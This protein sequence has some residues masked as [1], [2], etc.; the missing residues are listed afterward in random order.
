[1]IQAVVSPHRETSSSSSLPQTTTVR[2][3][4]SCCRARASFSETSGV[5]VPSNWYSALAG[6]V[7]GPS[8]L[9]IVRKPSCRRNRGGVLHRTVNQRRKTEADSQLVDAGADL[10]RCEFNINAKFFEHICGSRSARD[11]PVAMLGDRYP[12]G[13]GDECGRGADVERVQAVATGA[14]GV[15]ETRARAADQRAPFDHGAGGAHD[16]VDGFALHAQRRQ[17]GGGFRVGGFPVHDRTDGSTHLLGGEIA[18]RD[19]GVNG[20]G[21][22]CGHHQ[23]S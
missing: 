12:G 7:N 21:E 13:G 3:R 23:P 18:A 5:P 20:I 19:R 9:K 22:S 11:A 10:I 16:F 15:K 4:P 14:A 2:V 8:R 6:F 17:Q 1:M